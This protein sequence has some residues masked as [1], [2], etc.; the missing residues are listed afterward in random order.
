MADEGTGQV[1][2]LHRRL[3]TIDAMSVVIGAIIGVGIFFTPRRVAEVSGGSPLAMVAWGVCGLIAMLGALTFA[4]IGGMYPINGGQYA[5]LR[6]AYGKLVGFVYVFCNATAVQAG[7][8]GIIAMVC[9]E[10]LGVALTGNVPSAGVQL[11][12]SCALIGGLMIANGIGVRWGSGIQNLTVA[13]K[14]A[15]LLGV[16]VAALFAGETQGVPTGVAASE[17][18]SGMGVV[19]VL[20]AAMVA[21]FFS[22]GGWQSALWMA[23]EVKRPERTVPLAIVTGVAIVTAVYMLANWAYFRLL[24]FDGVVQSDALAASAVSAVW[25]KIGERLVAAAVG[26]SAFGVLNSQFLSGPRLISGM[27]VDGRFT[28][29]FGRSHATL[30]TP[31]ASI[32]LLGVIST[33]MLLVLGKDPLDALLT[34]VIV[35]DGLFFA[36]TGVAVIVLRQR[37]REFHRPVKVIGYPVVPALFALAML[38]I[39][40]GAGVDPKVRGTLLVGAAWIA[41]GVVMYFAAFHHWRRDAAGGE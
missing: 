22:Y 8:I 9:A 25:P 6:D 37:R 11:G 29:V 21:A 2:G 10:H 33:S 18:P 28:R 34:W 13:A 24:G 5:A 16:G 17:G 19:P 30:G 15:T 20:F 41:A 3:G 14:I 1:E 12:M 32:G 38:G 31:L 7:A 35:I 23:G 27:A 40:A 36:M 4:E 39:V 26:V